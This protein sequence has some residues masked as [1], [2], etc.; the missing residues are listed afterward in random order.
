[1]CF[2]KL[3]SGEFSFRSTIP[4]YTEPSSFMHYGC[5]M[6]PQTFW[7]LAWLEYYLSMKQH[8]SISTFTLGY[9]FLE[10]LLVRDE[11]IG[12]FKTFVHVKTLVVPLFV[13]RT[14][15]LE[16]NDKRFNNQATSVASLS[17]ISSM[18]LAPIAGIPISHSLLHLL[19]KN[20][21]SYNWGFRSFFLFQGD[22]SASPFF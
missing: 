21:P 19:Q 22:F 9:P 12:H 13:F 3:S 8:V 4:F 2:S 14:V 10:L 6:V 5:I 7:S 16:T 20:Y 18:I 1:M 17:I 11:I 15:R